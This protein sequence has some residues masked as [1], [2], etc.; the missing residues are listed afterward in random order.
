MFATGANNAWHLLPPSPFLVF[1]F[2]FHAWTSHQGCVA[3][4]SWAGPYGAR[5]THVPEVRLPQ[6][7]K[8]RELASATLRA[9]LPRWVNST[10]TEKQA[11]ACTQKPTPENNSNSRS[12]QQ[13]VD[14][15]VMNTKFDGVS[16]VNEA[17]TESND[18]TGGN[19]QIPPVCDED[20]HGSLSVVI[21][22]QNSDFEARRH[23]FL[24]CRDRDLLHQSQR[25][26]DGTVGQPSELSR[27]FCMMLHSLL[28]ESRRQWQEMLSSRATC[29]EARGAVGSVVGHVLDTESGA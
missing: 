4:M 1:F 26:I 17:G 3:S 10:G 22:R 8:P 6:R 18:N 16:I 12:L 19:G 24:E 15:T 28:A 20:V 11:G 13:D 21:R 27:P 29:I 23:S 2:F 7:G 14:P 25:A 9:A 5:A